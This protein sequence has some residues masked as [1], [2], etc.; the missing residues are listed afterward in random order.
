LFRSTIDE[1]P[2]G[3]RC[4]KGE[5]TATYNGRFAM[6]IGLIVTFVVVLA[7]LVF[8]LYALIRPF[9]HIHHDHNDVFHPPHLD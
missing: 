1:S 2:D 8:M 3:P 9:T 4:R 5:R 6:N 7:G